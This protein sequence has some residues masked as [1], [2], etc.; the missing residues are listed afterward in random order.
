MKKQPSIQELEQLGLILAS[1]NDILADAYWMAGRMFRRNS[2]AMKNLDVINR[3]LQMV[4]DALEKEA[5][6]YEYI[7]DVNVFFPVLSKR[8]KLVFPIGDD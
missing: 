7:D 5:F 1:V 6:R 4:R 8:G 3:N 2:L